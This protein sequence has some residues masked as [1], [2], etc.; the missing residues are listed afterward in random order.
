MADRHI[1]TLSCTGCKSKNYYF[2][3][4]KKMQYKLELKKFC[5]KCRKQT[6]HKE[7]K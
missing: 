1:T 6:P 3:H 2:S 5:S 4:V 7:T